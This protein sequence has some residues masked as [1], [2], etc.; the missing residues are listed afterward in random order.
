[1]TEKNV[2]VG[3]EFDDPDVLADVGCKLRLHGIHTQSCSQSCI[4]RFGLSF[5]G[6]MYEFTAEIKPTV[7]EKNDIV[8]AGSL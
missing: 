6:C 1:M 8:W 4:T 5:P 3:L 7:W 2:D